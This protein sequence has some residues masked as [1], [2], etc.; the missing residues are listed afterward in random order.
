MKGRFGCLPLWAASH[1]RVAQRNSK[2]F[3]P[4]RLAHV[5]TKLWTEL[6]HSLALGSAARI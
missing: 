6:A 4:G 3:V 5:W 2:G 1:P